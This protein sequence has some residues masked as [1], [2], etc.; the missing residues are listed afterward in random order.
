MGRA[1]H[2]T[3]INV[4]FSE[5]DPYGHVNHVVYLAYFE[6]GRVDVI[7]RLGWGLDRMREEGFGVIVVEVEMRYHAPAHYGDLLVVRSGIESVRPL[8]SWWTQ[9]VVRGDTLIASAR[10]RSASVDL[11]GRPTRAPSA[12]YDT[13]RELVEPR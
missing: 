10:V 7:D 11:D 3:P 5:L 6:Q 12:L 1:V 2:E 13:L 4:R 9:Q 8:S